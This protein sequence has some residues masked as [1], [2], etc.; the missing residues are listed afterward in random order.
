[1]Q[2]LLGG[3]LE[4]RAEQRIAE[5]SGLHSDSLLYSQRP[6]TPAALPAHDPPATA[7]CIELNRGFTVPAPPSLV[8]GSLVDTISGP[9]ILSRSLSRLD[10]WNPSSSANPVLAFR[11]FHR[12]GGA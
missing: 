8:L 6:P 10:L 2:A 3:S 11:P 1:M 12:H 5:L 9:K 4:N 7:A